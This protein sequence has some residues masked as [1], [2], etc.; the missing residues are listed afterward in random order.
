MEKHED[1]Q[2]CFQDGNSS[3]RKALL[4]TSIYITLYIFFSLISAV[5]VFL[6]ILVIISI[7]HFKQL[8]T[9]TN[10]LILSL[11]VSDLLVGLIVIPVVTVAVMESCWGFGEYFCVFHVY[12][13]FLCTSL[14]LGNLVLISIDR[15]VAVCD[16]LLYH[17]KIPT[18]AQLKIF[19]VARSQARKVFSKEAASV[20][21]VKTVQANKS[22]RKAA[23]TLAIVVVNYFIC[24]IPTLFILLFLSFLS[25]NLSRHNPL[26]NW[27]MGAIMSWSPAQ[28]AQGRL[29][30]GSEVAPGLSAIPTGYQDLR[31]VFS[32]SLAHPYGCGIDLLPKNKAM[33]TYVG[34]TPATGFIRPSSSPAG[35]RFF[36]VEKK[37]KAL[38]LCIVNR[39]LQGSTVFSKLDLRN[40]DHLVRMRE[41][42]EQKTAF[43]TASGHYENLVMPF[44]LTNTPIVFQALVNDVLRDIL[45]WFV[46]VYIDDIL[47]FS[48]SPKEHLLNDRQMDPEKV[49]TVVDWPQ[50]TSRVQLQRFLGFANFY[51]HFIQSYSTLASPLSTLT[52]TKDPFMWSS[53]IDWAL[54]DLKYP[55]SQW[56]VERIRYRILPQK[57]WKQQ[58]I[59]AASRRLMNRVIYSTNTTTTSEVLHTSDGEPPTTGRHSEPVPQQS[60]AV[61]PDGS[62]TTESSKVAT[63]ISLLTGRS[64]EWAIT[65]ASS[66]RYE[67]ALRT[68]FHSQLH[69]EVQTEF[70][71]RH[72]NISFNALIAMT[73]PGYTRVDG[74]PHDLRSPRMRITALG[75]RMPEDLLF[76]VGGRSCECPPAHQSGLFLDVDVDIHQAKERKPTPA[77]CPPKHIYFPLG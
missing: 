52:S 57:T 12:S 60:S 54:Q 74:R 55:W 7:S 53:A 73:N 34:D 71:C 17:S 10:L 64:L 61:H 24:W 70:T 77:T 43:N 15:Y 45:N 76:L 1:V 36:F 42:Y 27:S 25:D 39:P 3:C 37:D 66:G 31:E 30:G 50:N 9:P 4:S 56:S 38:R 65:A 28:P 59:T 32:K 14:S 33:E 26:I 13:T 21:G 68:L 62:P 47:V 48:R 5:T 72:D 69:E 67:P 46:F 11:A 20:S 49:R 2:Y 35:E 51:R 44:G 6:N 41:G 19:V 18:V 58:K 23:K 40:A 16:P 8:H 22:E 75:T 29:P 63:V